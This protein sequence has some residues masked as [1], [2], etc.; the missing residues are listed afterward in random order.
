MRKIF[1]ILFILQII[2]MSYVDAAVYTSNTFNNSLTSE[3]ISVS[4]PQTVVRYLDIPQSVFLTRGE[5][6]LT[7]PIALSAFD[8][9]VSYYKLDEQ[10]GTVV[11]DSLFGINNGTRT[12]G[13]INITGRIEKGYQLNGSQNNISIP[14]SQT[15]NFSQTN[16]SF[17]AWVY[18]QNYVTDFPLFFASNNT[19]LGRLFTIY[20]GETGATNVFTFR[21]FNVSGASHYATG[22]AV[23]TNRWIHLAAT[24]N[25]TSLVLYVNG[26]IVNNTFVFGD[27]ANTN[28]SH[29]LVNVDTG[30]NGL[31]NVTYDEIGFWNKSLTPS[32]VLTL[33]NNGSGQSL[34]NAA[35]PA[36]QGYI[37][38]SIGS[39][40]IQSL[41][42]AN[43]SVTN[44]SIFLNNL[45]TYVNSYLSTC[46]Y[47]SGICSV[48]FNFN[49][50]VG[51]VF[52]YYNLLNFSNI[53]LI[54]N[55]QN[56]SNDTFDTS[57]ERFRI[58]ITYDSSVYSS[59]SAI[60]IYNG[61]SY[62]GTSVGTGNTRDFYYDLNIPV[63]VSQKNHSFYWIISLSNFTN[64]VILNSTFRNQTVNPTNFSYCGIGSKAVNY[65]IYDEDTRVLVNS[66]FDATF[67]W[68]LNQ[69]GTITKNVSVDLGNLA[70]YTFCINTNRTFFTSADMLITSTGYSPRTFSFFEQPYSNTTTN[71]RLFLLNSSATNSRDITIILKDTG[72]TP[73]KDYTV[74]IYRPVEGTGEYILVENDVTDI[75]GQVVARLIENDIKYKFEFYS[76]SGI[77]VKTVD[78]GVITCTSAALFCKIQFVIEDTTNPFAGL[79]NLTSYEY[80]FTF[81][82]VTNIF[83]FSWT[84][85]RGESATHNLTVIRYAFNGTST[86]CSVASSSTSGSLSCA[87][88]DSRASY[89]AQVLRIVGTQSRRISVISVKVGDLSGVFGL[90]GFLWSA[91]LLLTMIIFGIFY[92]PVGVILYIAGV[93][94]LGIF[95]IMFINPAIIIAQLVIGGLF[96]WSFRG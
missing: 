31:N 16:F 39:T 55:S 80:F 59:S 86:I 93:L 7:F 3:T 12:G 26:T 79:S 77:L 53:E 6:N 15:F 52:I 88:G 29:F 68:K 22:G 66:T 92:P 78:K 27:I 11:T 58:N 84:D 72:L 21:F 95:D 33:Y 1:F 47:V 91:M 64:T 42:I 90:E 10:S 32:E 37:N 69:S 44:S 76:T 34:V 87:V 83:T 56:F 18:I 49:F 54:E 75:F 17:S 23:G 89:Q 13:L 60:L 73:L 40:P 51:G 24:R 81:N 30:N 5:L 2:F 43:N 4:T 25:S 67:V 63:V 14:Y 8:K 38:V 50:T 57:V 71:Q 96:I 20:P 61:T 36:S 74:K 9:L 41:S 45:K 85:T 70:N 46:T 28:F 94:L 19:N 65:S 48:P 35:T 62:L 82:N